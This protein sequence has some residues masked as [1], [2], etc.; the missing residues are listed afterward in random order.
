MGEKRGGGL[1][2]EYLIGRRD[3]RKAG[4]R[5]L[6]AMI[7]GRYACHEVDLLSRR[8]TIGN[9]GARYATFPLLCLTSP[10]D[11]NDISA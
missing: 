6:P 4:T 1:V 3:Q 7:A 8:V 9:A 5:L 11:I 2:E 10:S